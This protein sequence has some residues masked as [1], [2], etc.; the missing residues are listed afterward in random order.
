MVAEWRKRRRQ[1]VRA[2]PVVVALLAAAC[3]LLLLAN[4]VVSVPT[5]LAAIIIGVSVFTVVGDVIN[6]LYFGYKLRQAAEP[7][8]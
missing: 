3:V 8:V 6:I 5:W 4:L 7:R 2:L 1:S